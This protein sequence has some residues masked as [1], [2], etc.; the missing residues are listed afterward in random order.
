MAPQLGSECGSPVSL[1]WP[2]V[3][4]PLGNVVTMSGVSSLV[5]QVTFSCHNIHT[6]FSCHTA[7]CHYP[8]LCYTQAVRTHDQ[9][10]RQRLHRCYQLVTTAI[11]SLYLR[12]LYCTVLCCTVLYCT[13]GGAPLLRLPGQAR[14]GCVPQGAQDQLQPAGA[15]AG[16]PR[17]RRGLHRGR[18]GHE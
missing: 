5:S 9:Y 12:T 2:G 13:A 14:H 15:Q 10:V 7:R 16:Q 1:R 18:G 3:L 11:I 8:H 17:L 6:S 4:P